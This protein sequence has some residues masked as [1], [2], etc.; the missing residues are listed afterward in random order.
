MGNLSTVKKI[1]GL[2]EFIAVMNIIRNRVCS[3]E[4]LA[5]LLQ[6][7]LAH[8][9]RAKNQLISQETGQAPYPFL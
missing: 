7:A 3:Q 1:Y 8:S 5:A 6:E 4:L 2:L 9:T